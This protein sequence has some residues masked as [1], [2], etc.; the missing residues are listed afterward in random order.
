MERQTFSS[1]EWSRDRVEQT[2]ARIYDPEKVD[3]A[4]AVGRAADATAIRDLLQKATRGLGLACEEAA[5]LLQVEAPGLQ[6]EIIEAAR[7]I[8]AEN[9]R[10]RITLTTPIC[11]SNRCVNDC[12]YCPLRRSDAKLK[13]RSATAAEVQREVMALLDEG[14][15]CLMVVMGDDRSGVPYLRDLVSAVYGVRSGYRQIERVDIN[16]N[17]LSLAELREL[18]QALRLGIYHVFQETYDP[19]VYARLHPDGPKSD[20]AWRLTCHDRAYEA[21]FE[22]V[23]MGILLGVSDYRPDIVAMLMHAQYLAEI[24]P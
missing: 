14:Y 8:H 2:A 4:L 9:F 22:T 19:E 20:Y 5:A 1:T 18:R 3:K 7:Q 10:R 16:I 23:G 6:A 15:R 17:P 21:G 11:P 12:L 13:R 24:L